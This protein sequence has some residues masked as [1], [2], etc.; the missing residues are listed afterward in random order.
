ME[1]KESKIP[2]IEEQIRRRRDFFNPSL[3]SVWVEEEWLRF[4]VRRYKAST[5]SGAVN[6][7]LEEYANL[8]IDQAELK[9]KSQVKEQG[10]TTTRSIKI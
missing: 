10:A 7:A 9:K 8:L 6:R 4:F 2:P 3:V 1:I 5:I